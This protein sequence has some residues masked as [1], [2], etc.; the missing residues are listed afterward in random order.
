LLHHFA[1]FFV[2]A[3]VEISSKNNIPFY[4]ICACEKLNNFVKYFFYH[5]DYFRKT[6]LVDTV[7]LNNWLSKTV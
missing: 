2:V 6:V 5:L 1:L 4:C 7:Q 3:V